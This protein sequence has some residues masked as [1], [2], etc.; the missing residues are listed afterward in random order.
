MQCDSGEQC[1]QPTCLIRPAEPVGHIEP[2]TISRAAPRSGSTAWAW[3]FPQSSE[4]F[5]G[6]LVETRDP[7]QTRHRGRDKR[8]IWRDCENHQ[9]EVKFYNSLQDSFVWP[10]VMRNI[11]GCSPQA[12]PEAPC[13]PACPAEPWTWAAAWSGPAHPPGPRWR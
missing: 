10:G 4:C 6:T 3:P 1:S 2:S 12:F 5:L 7:D 8:F 11:T 9:S 13:A